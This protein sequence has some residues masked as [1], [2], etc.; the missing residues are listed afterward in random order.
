MKK[1]I[2]LTESQLVNMIKKTVKR[3]IAEQLQQAPAPKPVTT[4]PTQQAPKTATTGKIEQALNEPGSILFRDLWS[5]KLLDYKD[6]ANRNI[7]VYKGGPLSAQQLTDLNNHL[8]KGGYQL[9]AQKGVDGKEKYL[10]VKGGSPTAKPTTAANISTTTIATYVDQ[11]VDLLDG[12]VLLDDL[13]ALSNIVTNLYGKT[14]SG[15]NNALAYFLSLYMRDESGDS[16]IADVQSVGTKTLPAE[17][18]TLKDK[19]IA[20]AKS[21]L[22]KK[23]AAA[24]PGPLA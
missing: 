23:Q 19:I 4:A 13:K 21:A 16:F 15:G 3:V 14:L 6:P 20:T 11:A 18:I 24:K 8:Q 2:R 1:R 22:A 12:V 7:I 10:W 9:K 5:K 17:A